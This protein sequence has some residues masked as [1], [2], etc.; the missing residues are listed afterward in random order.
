MTASA[1]QFE[2][3]D[4]HV[5][6][7]A[8]LPPPPGG[9][10][11][12]AQQLLRLLQAEGVQVEAVQIN[13]PYSPGLIK[14]L[15]GLRALF[16]L[17][18]YMLNLW[19]TAGRV[20]LFHVLANSGWSWHL[21]AVPAIWIGWLRGIPVIV[22]YRGGGADAFFNRSWRFVYPSLKRASLITVPSGFLED[23]FSRR[24]VTAV[25]VPNI[26]DLSCFSS[27]KN[28][29]S[30]VQRAYPRLLVAR[31]LE[32]LYDNATAI[33]AFHIVRNEYTEA[34][35]TIVGDGPERNS[36]KKLV[37]ELG[38]SNAVRFTGKLDNAE[39][40]ALYQTTDISLNPSL[41]DN[42]PISVLESLA[43]GVPVVSTNV[44]GVPYLLEDECTGLLV[45]PGDPDAMAKAILRLLHDASLANSLQ[46]NAALY[47]QRFK[48]ASVMPVLFAAY[49]QV[50]NK[51]SS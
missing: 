26:I 24:G 29:S 3:A 20:S 43:S 21:F 39:L 2:H 46:K 36:L 31:N 16:R 8:P 10:A 25:V 38:L 35:L 28:K 32:A 12:Q 51:G 48:W 44:G 47:V 9:M 45:P 15:W 41:I 11:N 5:G 27:L 1:Q 23:V 34:Q 50:F 17:I 49:K 13:R 30:D 22:N 7:V 40:P 42:T 37:S 33:R 6:L 19:Q 4:L 14:H 18:P